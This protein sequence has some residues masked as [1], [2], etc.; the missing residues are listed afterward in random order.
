[1]S[2]LVGAP[3]GYVGYEEGG[4]LT[5]KVRRKPYSVILFDEVEKAHPDVFN[6]LLQALDEGQMTDSLGRKIDF[7]N[8]VIIMTSNIG[9]RQLK[10]F[11]TGVGFGT[12]NKETNRDKESKQVIETQLRKFFSPEFLNRIDDVIVFNSLAK[13]EIIQILDIR[14]KKV[15]KR[16]AEIGYHVELTETAKSFLADKGFDPD[17]GARPLQRALQKYMEEPLAEQ[18]LQ[19]NLKEGA[20]LKV[21]HAEGADE[22]L[23]TVAA[24]TLEAGSDKKLLNAAAETS[25]AGQD[26]VDA[27]KP[28]RGRASKKDTGTAD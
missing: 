26:A 2:R 5:E 15:L 21:D 11:G 8:T 1:V 10:D 16:I 25:D 28:K 17:F 27:P 4:M 22:L 12:Q 6:L 9:S 13:E 24:R 20:Y 3:P 18:V 23:I 14:M 19:G 7:R